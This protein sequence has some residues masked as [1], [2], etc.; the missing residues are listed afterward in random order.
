MKERK[1]QKK[2]RREEKRWVNL[3]VYM[4]NGGG[5]GGKKLPESRKEDLYCRRGQKKRG[6]VFPSK[7]AYFM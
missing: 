7:K 2:K 1:L 4:N 3:P 5:L 6:G